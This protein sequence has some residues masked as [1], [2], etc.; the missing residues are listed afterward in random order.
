VKLT[1]TNRPITYTTHPPRERT[2]QKPFAPKGRVQ[3]N[4]TACVHYVVPKQQ[5]PHKGTVAQEP[6]HNRITCCNTTDFPATPQGAGGG[7]RVTAVIARGKRP[8]PFRTRKLRPAAPMVLHPGGC[9]RVGHRRN[10]IQ[11]EDPNHQVGVL[12]HLNIKYTR[13]TQAPLRYRGTPAPV[14]PRRQASGRT[15]SQSPT[16]FWSRPSAIA[17]DW[18]VSRSTM[19]VVHGS[20]RIHELDSGSRKYRTDRGGAPSRLL[21]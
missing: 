17:R 7:A 10:T 13:P 6:N 19:V 8:V 11:V 21:G 5:T 18:P 3:R 4:K 14:T 1:G 15:K 12:P 2:L 16:P 9:G 20:C